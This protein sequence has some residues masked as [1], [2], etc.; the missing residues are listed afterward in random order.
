MKG[1]SSA[2][3]LFASSQRRWLQRHV[4]SPGATGT[5]GGRSSTAWPHAV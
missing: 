5:S 1:K 4:T 2:Q 3:T